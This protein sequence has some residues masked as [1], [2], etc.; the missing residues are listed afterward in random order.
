MTYP[1]GLVIFDLDGTLVDSAADIAEAVNRTLRDWSLPT[2]TTDQVIAW[3]GEGSRVLMRR[4]LDAAGGMMELDAVMPGFLVHYGDTALGAHA[5]DGVADALAGLRARGVHVAVCTNKNEAFVAPLL[6]ALG[7]GVH[8]EAIVG[9]DTLAERKPSALPL[10][11]LAHRFGVA[12]EACL[13]VGDSE[14]DL[15]AARAAGMPVVL[16]SYGYH[17][18]LDLAGAGAVAVVDDLRALL[19][20]D[21]RG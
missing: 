16:V 1:Y 21:T 4:A 8:V 6:D 5:Y 2:F 10:L 13:M 20:L 15:L 14:S 18:A 3:V 19:A 7:L 9:G 17:H 11:H 12:A